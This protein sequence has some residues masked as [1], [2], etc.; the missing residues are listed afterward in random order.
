MSM[1]HRVVVLYYLWR[2]IPRQEKSLVP[3]CVQGHKN[4]FP[5]TFHLQLIE[6]KD[7]EHTGKEEQLYFVK[8]ILIF[9]LSSLYKNFIN[10]HLE[11]VVGKSA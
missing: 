3:I 8:L 6:F 1:L 9:A 5:V 4:F 11:M 10:S 7:V 2:F